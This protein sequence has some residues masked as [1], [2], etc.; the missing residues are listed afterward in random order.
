MQL[1]IFEKEFYRR[2]SRITE[3]SIYFFVVFLLLFAWLDPNFPYS[4]G[5]VNYLLGAL[6]IAI[7]YIW[8]NFLTPHIDERYINFVESFLDV[9]IIT[10]LVCITGGAGSIFMLLFFLPIINSIGCYKATH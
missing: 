4:Y 7:N 1:N 10:L 5:W 8:H 3:I 9:L 6:I 2:F